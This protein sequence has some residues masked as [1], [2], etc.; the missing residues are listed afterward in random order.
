MKDNKHPHHDLIALFNENIT[1]K[2]Q[3]LVGI[4]WL[5]C[6]IID[7]VGDVTGLLC[8]RAKPREFIKGHWYPCYYEGRE[9]ICKFD[10]SKLVE[11][12]NK[13]YQATSI[14]WN[15]DSCYGLKVGKSLGAIKFGE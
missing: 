3:K 14:T 12:I 13:G 4:S 2:V 15:G 8:F 1:T 10:G 7:V 6:S 5:G 9:F 11:P